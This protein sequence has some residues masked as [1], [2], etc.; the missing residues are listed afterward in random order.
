MKTIIPRG[1]ITDAF[2][3]FNITTHSGETKTV[4]AKGWVDYID[5]YGYPNF[6]TIERSEVKWFKMIGILKI[7][8]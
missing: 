2:H 8:K 3:V 1:D 5:Y 4:I 6:L 7:K